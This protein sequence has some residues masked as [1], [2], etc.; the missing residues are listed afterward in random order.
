MAFQGEIAH[1]REGK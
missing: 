1:K